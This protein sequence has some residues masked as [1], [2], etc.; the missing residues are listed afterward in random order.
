MIEAEGAVRTGTR[1]RSPSGRVLNVG[2]PRLAGTLVAFGVAASANGASTL[3]FPSPAAAY[4]V[5]EGASVCPAATSS[6]GTQAYSY[7]IDDEPEWDQSAPGYDGTFRDLAHAAMSEWEGVLQPNGQPFV[8]FQDSGSAQAGFKL[9]WD[10]FDPGV[11]AV[12]IDPPCGGLALNRARLYNTGSEPGLG[13]IPGLAKSVIR[14]EVG[15]LLGL[16]HSGMFDS[17]PE[18]L[19]PTMS[20]CAKWAVDSEVALNALTNNP[21]LFSMSGDDRGQL[22][23]SRSGTHHEPLVDQWFADASSD[24]GFERPG[25]IP[26]FVWNSGMSRLSTGGFA[27]PKHIQYTPLSF[28]NQKFWSVVNV[29]PSTNSTPLH[30][31]VR[32]KAR[33]V[34][35]TDQKFMTVEVPFRAVTYRARQVGPPEALPTSC[36]YSAGRPTVPLGLNQNVRITVG[37][38]TNANPRV[39]PM[40]T[41]DW[42]ELGAVNGGTAGASGFVSMD[43]PGHTSAYDFG[44]VVRSAVMD[45]A[46]QPAPVLLDDVSL[47]LGAGNYP[48]APPHE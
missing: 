26:W 47:L 20:T 44:V 39:T 13:V 16:D 36:S 24:V 43:F 31:S 14:H 9:L 17:W 11:L 48:A 41:K 1:E 45:S 21:S 33:K 25:P 19:H 15:H 42:T 37:P 23:Y 35:A 27:G 30:I 32:A 7:W 22:Q 18:S 12:N 10:G 4:P 6:G 8:D 40:A 29:V 3:P 2:K 5:G 28:T 38:W 34:S 46:G